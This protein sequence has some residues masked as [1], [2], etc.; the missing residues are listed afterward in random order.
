VNAFHRWSTRNS[1]AFPYTERAWR[2][3]MYMVEL[4]PKG[5]SGTIKL[6]TSHLVVPTQ[7]T[8]EKGPFHSTRKAN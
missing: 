2:M 6:T 3:K 8:S 1:N 5:S 7:C 4:A